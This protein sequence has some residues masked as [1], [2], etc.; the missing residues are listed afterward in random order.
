ML[1][2][3]VQDVIS[4]FSGSIGVYY[5]NLMTG[6]EF[7]IN[8]EKAF[9]AASVIK[10]AVMVEVFHQFTQGRLPLDKLL[11]VQDSDKVPS[12]GVIRLMHTGLNVTVLDLCYL[13]IDISDNT[14]TNMLI[15]QVGMDNINA[16]MQS[17]GLQQT[18]VNRLLFDV[19][20]REAGLQ[21]YFAPKEIGILLEKMWRGDLVSAEASQKMLD[22]LLNQQLNHKIPY[23][24]PDI[25]IA[26]KTGEDDG[27]THDTGII[28][29]EQPFILCL[30]SN[31]TNV[32]ETEHGFRR[33]AQICYEKS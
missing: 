12:C 20:A 32:P 25:P 24:L 7:G 23:Y 3:K 6:E 11:I 14:A 26:H 33:I 8:E 19:K 5:K 16:R 28:Y 9:V 27:T 22:I 17:L 13:M 30:A 15:N 18:R 1:L 2:Q 31:D 4:N 10:I 21:N 29:A